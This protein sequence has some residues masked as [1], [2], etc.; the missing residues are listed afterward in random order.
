M[1][2][3][4]SETPQ[5]V[6]PED[7]ELPTTRKKSRQGRIWFGIAVT[8]ASIWYAARGIPFS[9]VLDSIRGADFWS[10]L[11][12]SMPFY[13]WSNVIRALRWRHLMKPVALIDRP[14]LYRA[15]A[16]GF[17][18]NNL[19]PLRVGELARSWMLH[20]EGE[21]SLSAVIGTV[22]LERILDAVTVLG[23]ALAALA[24]VEQQ[25]DLGGILQRG[26]KLLL[27][28]ALLPIAVIIVMRAAPEFVIRTTR[29]LLRPF[30]TSIQEKVESALRGFILGLAALSGG[31][32][33]FW[34]AWHSVVLW[35]VTAT[36]PFL[37]GFWA[38]GVDLRSFWESL[39]SAWV[40]LGAVGVAV[41]LPSAPGF[42]GPYQLAFKAVL[43]RFGIDP[44]TALAM[45]ILVW[46]VFWLS[47]TL[48]GVVALRYSRVRLSELLSFRR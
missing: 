5:S 31:R 32:H 21:V 30:S 27:P 7:A 4:E 2:R 10:L 38:F 16:V 33:L 23:L 15:T 40:L 11:L 1:N 46:F 14:M 18:V 19:L 41:A 8:V 29:R 43:V 48:Q 42:I 9:S 35:L 22:A 39:L 12:L 28:A 34:I 44:A 24:L 37:L 3:L 25:S 17:M 47:M 20:R 13:I 26:S 45:G 36:A 6:E